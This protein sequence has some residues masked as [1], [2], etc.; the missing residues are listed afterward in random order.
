MKQKYLQNKNIGGVNSQFSKVK[1]KQK[2][3]GWLMRQYFDAEN[4]HD[5]PW[6]RTSVTP[7]NVLQH[8][9]ESKNR[10][11]LTPQKIVDMWGCIESFKKNL[12][13]SEKELGPDLGLSEKDLLETKDQPAIKYQTG[14][15][16]LKTIGNVL[17]GLTPTM[18]NKLCTSGMEKI[19]VM[20]G[21]ISLEDLDEDVAEQLNN[22]IMSCRLKA[23]YEYAGDLKRSNGQIKSFVESLVKQRI[24][25]AHDIKLI[26]DQEVV[27]LTMLVPKSIQEIVDV[28]LDD[29]QQEENVFKTYQSAVARKAFPEKKRG[30][31]RK[32][33]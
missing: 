24:M 32:N 9:S 33:A 28:L 29:I 4:N 23:A 10:F 13:K 5:S 6:Y 26:Q 14:E 20:S 1:N 17:G 22:A 30:R 19:R 21:G 11:P 18:I 7:K 3:I 12:K 31:P 16:T 27:A 8:I 15:A 25:T 2:M